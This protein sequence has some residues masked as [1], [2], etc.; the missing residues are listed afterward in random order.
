MTI[1]SSGASQHVCVH[2]GKRAAMAQLNAERAH[3]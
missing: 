1:L 3:L 2:M